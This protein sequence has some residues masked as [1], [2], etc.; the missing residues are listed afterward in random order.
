[1][2]A[3]I[4]TASL[5][6]AVVTTVTTTTTVHPLVRITIRPRARVATPREATVPLAIRAVELLLVVAII[7]GGV[8]TEGI[9]GVD[10]TVEDPQE[11]TEDKVEVVVAVAVLDVT[12]TVGV[13]TARAVAVVTRGFGDRNGGN[14]GMVVQEDTIFVSGMDPGVSEEEICQHFGA[15]GIIKNDK[16]TGK[17]KIWVYRDKNTGKPKGE[18][19]VTYDDQDAARSAIVWF[20]GKDFKG[21]TIKVQMA[22]HKSNWQGGRGGGRGGGAPG[23]GRG[24]GGFGGRGGGGDRDGGDHHRGGGGDD[25]RDSGGRGGDWRCTNPDCG[26]TNFAWRDECNLCKS[27]KPEGAGGG[28]G[29]GG[30]GGRG[31][32]GGDRGGRGGGF[33]N[34]RGRGGDRGG[35]GGGGGFRGGDRG[36][37]GGRGRGGPMRGGGGRGDRDRDRQRPY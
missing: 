14:D 27:S 30:G 35:R 3:T 11:V 5:H 19:T 26:N 34:D 20:D 28:G 4:S 10:I 33:R 29:G 18:A 24:R 12:A 23:G 2:Q 25:R 9:Q 6:P 13:T 7:T 37:S 8:I 16:R 31:G 32:R 21:C 22:Q 15:I 36:G 1:M 17:P